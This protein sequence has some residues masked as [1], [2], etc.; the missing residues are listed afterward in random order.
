MTI[1]RRTFLALLLAAFPALAADGIASS[2]AFI[3]A[4]PEAKASAAAPPSIAAS[5]ASRRSWV[6]LPS[7]VYS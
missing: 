7:R 4:M 5:A 1:I 6:G 2:S 3:A